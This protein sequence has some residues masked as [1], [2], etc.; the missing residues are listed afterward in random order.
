VK[1]AINLEYAITMLNSKDPMN[2]NK[3]GND[4]DTDNSQHILLLKIKLNS[5]YTIINLCEV[6]QDD[7]MGEEETFN[8]SLKTNSLDDKI[9]Y[10]LYDVDLN[11]QEFEE[12]GDNQWDF[13]KLSKKRLI[14]T[15]IKPLKTI[16]FDLRMEAI[17]QMVL[18]VHDS[19][20]SFK[21]CLPLAL[22]IRFHRGIPED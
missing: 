3:F 4:N 17:E 22:N 9:I 5:D 18:S 8:A 15:F 21:S 1:K 7:H 11:S 16:A 12:D 10:E 19:A 2:I 14:S 6:S 13:N 20:F